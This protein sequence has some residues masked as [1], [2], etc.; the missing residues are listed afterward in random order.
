[1]RQA[2]GPKS[3]CGQHGPNEHGLAPLFRE[4]LEIM[5]GIYWDI[6]EGKA[7]PARS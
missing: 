4:G 2:T 1:M 7:P 5:A 6:G 3:G